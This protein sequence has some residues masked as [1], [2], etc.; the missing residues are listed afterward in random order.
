M[1]LITALLSTA[2]PFIVSALTQGIKKIPVVDAVNKPQRAGLLIA[3][4]ALLSIGSAAVSFAVTGTL[5]EQT[6]T[7]GATAIITFVTTQIIYWFG[8]K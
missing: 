8:K 1:E 4:V 5:D 6:V 2:S 3:F 7:A